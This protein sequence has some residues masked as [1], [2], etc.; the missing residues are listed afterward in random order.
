MC[1]PQKKMKLD[2]CYIMPKDA[3]NSNG[4]HGDY[5]QILFLFPSAPMV[6]PFVTENNDLEEGGPGKQV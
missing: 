2:N 4:N 6:L 3:K 1:P 5:H